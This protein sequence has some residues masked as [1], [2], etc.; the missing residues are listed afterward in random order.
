M[1]VDNGGEGQSKERLKLHSCG[2]CFFCLVVVK[3]RG[4]EEESG[5]VVLGVGSELFRRAAGR[6]EP[7]T[8]HE[9]TVR[10]RCVSL[11]EK[12][13]HEDDIYELVLGDVT[14]DNEEKRKKDLGGQKRRPG[15]RGGVVVYLL[16]PGAGSE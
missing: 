4:E 7:S 3:K 16:G 10:P 15:E 14:G 11:R 2:V 1:G 5:D 13:N 9:Q 12:Y 6:V 8:V